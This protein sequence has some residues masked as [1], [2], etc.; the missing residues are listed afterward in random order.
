M[1]DMKTAVILL[2]VIVGACA[3]LCLG[4]YFG[5][6]VEV[7]R[8]VIGAGIVALIAIVIFAIY[9]AWYLITKQP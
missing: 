1:P 2:G 5:K 4:G 8:V 7:F 3:L 9:S 6:K